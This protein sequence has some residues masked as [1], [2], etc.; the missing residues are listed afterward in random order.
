[1]WPQTPGDVS[2]SL[3]P[4][5]EVEPEL[6]HWSS[7][8]LQLSEV[9]DVVGGDQT[10]LLLLKGCTGL[11]KESK[12]A[13]GQWRGDKVE[14]QSVVLVGFPSPPEA[15]TR[16]WPGV[17]G[18]AFA[19]CG[20]T[21]WR[22]QIPASE[23]GATGVLQAQATQVCTLPPRLSGVSCQASE[24]GSL[25]CA[26]LVKAETPSTPGPAITAPRQS[27]SQLPASKLCI[28]EPPRGLRV[29]AEVPR[30]SEGPVLSLSGSRV[31]WKVMLNEV[32]EEAERGEFFAADVGFES[33]V[34]INLT[35]GAGRVG[36]CDVSDDGIHFLLQANFSKDRP[37]TTHMSLVLVTWPRGA[38]TPSAPET[39]V[40][41][42][43]ILNFNFLPGDDTPTFAVT[44]LSG[45]DPVT[46]IWRCSGVG[47]SQVSVLSQAVFSRSLAVLQR[48]GERWAAF[49]TEGLD[50]LPSLH[51]ASLDSEASVRTPLPQPLGADTLRVE[52]VVYPF[53]GAT[54]TGL[55]CE[56]TEPPLPKDAPLLVNVHGGPACAFVGST[57]VASGHTRYPYRLY[58]VA[59]YRVFLPLFR[60][61]LGFGDE[62]AQANIGQQ[63]SLEADLGD[64]LAGLDWLN[65]EHPRLRGTV[66]PERT[67]I[68]GGSYGGYLTMRA[69]S[70]VPERF[71]A[72]VAEYGF[73]HNRWMSYEGGDFTW[74]DEYMTPSADEVEKATGV[75]AGT[76]NIWPLPA[77]MQMSD[78][79]ND[80]HRI[81]APMLLMHG[82]KD[83]ICPLS[84][85]RV[86]FHMLEK[87]SV[88]TGLI[89]Y[90]GEGHGF[91]EP[92]HQQDRDRRILL[93]WREHL[94]PQLG[95][96]P[97]FRAV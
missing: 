9:I 59:G 92:H 30:L 35:E 37:I 46:S 6:D 25:R 81:A 45:V 70:S 78:C 22:V 55:L 13:L 38:K 39:L 86:A 48:A 11:T 68:F 8:E 53:K 36:E 19:K 15:C 31:V 2:K 65:E 26:M 82:E 42:Q 34:V 58:L 52:K 50:E 73:V 10:L 84:Q 93:W 14:L 3:L 28:F 29:A 24:D 74:E 66:A 95:P 4:R 88:P 67:G 12:L 87:R 85:S 90:P 63:G 43:H 32:P 64:V 44:Q 80:L 94:P 96:V 76:S 21:V 62:W 72:G 33:A 1:M 54:V 18:S 49:G 91:D 17:S 47:A 77:S 60:G 61:G 57:R 16:L 89:V 23:D 41:G 97:D 56:R 71:G 69:M 83:D 20:E 40:Q 75:A 79:F 5:V 27:M 7:P 51:L